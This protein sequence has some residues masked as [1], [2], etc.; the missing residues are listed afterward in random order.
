[1]F[2]SPTSNK[3]D[4]AKFGGWE[5]EGKAIRASKPVFDFT[6]RRGGKVSNKG[7]NITVE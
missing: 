1:V 3:N 5:P 6:E 7:F 4:I 2:S